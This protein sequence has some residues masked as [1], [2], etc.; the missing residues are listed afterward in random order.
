MLSAFR[1]SL[2]SWSCSVVS[3]STRAMRPARG[4][5][6][7]TGAEMGVMIIAPIVIAA[8]VATTALRAGTLASQDL[9]SAGSAA[10]AQVAT[11]IQSN[12]LVLA[13]TD[14][15]RVTHL[16]VDITT[17]PGSAPVSLDPRASADRTTVVYIDHEKVV[18]DVRYSVTWISDNGDNMLDAGELAELDIDLGAVA[19]AEAFTIEIRPTGGAFVSLRVTPPG[20]GGLPLLL[21]LH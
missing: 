10:V 14:G 5:R 9:Q 6:G 4:Q 21:R 3:L 7:A 16:L 13:R 12:D 8:T 1:A 11:G 2:T 15:T 17:T 18:R 20:T 19:S